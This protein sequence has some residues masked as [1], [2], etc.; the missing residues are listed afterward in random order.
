MTNKQVMERFTKRLSGN[1]NNLYTDGNKLINYV[2]EIA[3]FK[4][5]ICFVNVRKYS[6]TTSKIQS[7]L[8]RVLQ[9]NNVKMEEYVSTEIFRG[10][11]Y[12]R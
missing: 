11:I 2:T 3:Y 12:W 10:G 8:K 5:G 6:N 1:A 9:E 4:E 7:Q